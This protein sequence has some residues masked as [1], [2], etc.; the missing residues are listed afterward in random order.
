MVEHGVKYHQTNKQTNKQTLCYIPSQIPVNLL[1][2][3]IVPFEN[4]QGPHCIL[5]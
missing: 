5:Q 3:V 2:D 1:Q 4:V